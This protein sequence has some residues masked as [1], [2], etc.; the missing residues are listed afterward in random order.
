MDD[1]DA[2]AMFGVVWVHW[3]IYNISATA[4][5]LAEGASTHVDKLPAGSVETSSDFGSA[6][7]RGPCPPSGRHHYQFQLYALNKETI[8]FSGPLTRTEFEAAFADSII[9][10]ASTAGYFR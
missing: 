5:E 6:K 10:K 7:Y 8:S 2:F 4:K 9:A 1:P 3:N